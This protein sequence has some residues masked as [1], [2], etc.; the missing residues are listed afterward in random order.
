MPHFRGGSTMHR[1]NKQ[2]LIDMFAVAGIFTA[3][4]MIEI[5]STARRTGPKKR[6]S[7]ICFLL[8]GVTIA[9]FGIGIR[10]V[11]GSG[12]EAPE[13]L[14]GVGCA[15][16]TS[17]GGWQNFAFSQQT[18]SFTAEFD[19]T[20]SASPID[21]VVGPSLGAQTAYTGFAVLARFSPTGN[22]D[23]RN[24]GAYAA[25]STIP[26]SANVTYHFRLVVNVPA[27]TYSVFV[28]PAGGSEL[29]VGTNF[30]FRTEQ[31]TVTSLDWWGTVVNASTPGSTTVCNFTNTSETEPA[32]LHT[33]RVSS[34]S[35]LQSQIN[36]A[37][38]GDLIILTNGVYTSSATINIDR[39]GTAQNPIVISAD[40]IG[41][42]EIGGSASFSV[43]SPA[44]WIV[45]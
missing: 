37:L 29:T 44:S 34:I 45:I 12:I 21:S 41:G 35:A 9:S 2:L 18:G 14:Q 30:A 7:L 20:P 1:L 22:I 4:K 10:V 42:A 43:N 11:T 38:P 28:R 27:H 24:G 5:S 32:P 16:V 15:T 8:L 33:F 26:F 31:N 3:I 25:A 40:T 39:Q 36:S 17:G 13:P 19:A 23:A 6:F